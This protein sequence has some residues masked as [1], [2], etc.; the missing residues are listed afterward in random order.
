MPQLRNHPLPSNKYC[1]TVSS[2]PQIKPNAQ[3]HFQLLPLSPLSPLSPLPTSYSLH[4][5]VG[6]NSV[7]MRLRAWGHN[8]EVLFPDDLRDRIIKDLHAAY[9][10]YQ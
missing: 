2:L 9:Q 7:I 8:V 3:Q 6:D 1:N 5:R 10:V 4:Y